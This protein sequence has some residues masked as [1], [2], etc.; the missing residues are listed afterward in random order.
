MHK[1]RQDRHKGQSE[2]QLKP[3][4]YNS[5]LTASFEDRNMVFSCSGK[6]QG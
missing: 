3:E 5:T 1:H 6:V 2:E 4:Y